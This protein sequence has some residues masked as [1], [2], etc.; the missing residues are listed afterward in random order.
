MRH[1]TP[2]QIITYIIIVLVILLAIF[3]PGNVKAQ[4][5]LDSLLFKL[6]DYGTMQYTVP[7]GIIDP[8]TGLQDSA[9]FFVIVDSVV[10][11]SV[12]NESLGFDFFHVTQNMWVSF[13]LFSDTGRSEII[14]QIFFDSAGCSLDTVITTS[15]VDIT[16]WPVVLIYIV[17]EGAPAWIKDLRGQ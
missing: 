8:I 9:S 6:Q 17:P 1:R 14:S 3:W 5:P 16:V 10:I 15:Q 11:D 7:Y 2:I 4:L 13:S 12:L